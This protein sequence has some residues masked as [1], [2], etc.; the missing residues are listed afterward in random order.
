MLRAE[1]EGRPISNSSNFWSNPT[2][3]AGRDRAGAWKAG[4]NGRR[5]G[6]G[7]GVSGAEQESFQDDLASAGNQNGSWSRSQRD[8]F[9]GTGRERG[10]GR[11]RG[12]SRGRDRDRGSRGRGGG[13]SWREGHAAE[14]ANPSETWPDLG[15]ATGAGQ[16]V[17]TAATTQVPSSTGETTRG[18]SR[19]E[20]GNGARGGKSNPSGWGQPGPGEREM[21][22]MSSNLED[23]QNQRGSSSY[24][25]GP[26]DWDDATAG[27]QSKGNN[28]SIQGQRRKP[29]WHS[30]GAPDAFEANGRDVAGRV[31]SRGGRG[32]RRQSPSRPRRAPPVHGKGHGASGERRREDGGRGQGSSSGG[33]KDRNQTAKPPASPR[34]PTAA[35]GDGTGWGKPNSART[36]DEEVGGWV[37]TEEVAGSSLQA[38]ATST[39]PTRSNL[40][41]T[42]APPL[43]RSLPSALTADAKQWTGASRSREDDASAAA[44]I[45][46]L[47]ASVALLPALSGPATATA[48][49]TAAGVASGARVAFGEETAGYAQDAIPMNVTAAAEA[50]AGPGGAAIVA[51]GVEFGVGGNG[52]GAVPLHLQ[53]PSFVAPPGG[54]GGVGG[55]LGSSGFVEGVG[56]ETLMAPLSHLPPDQHA[57]LLHAHHQHLVAQVRGVVSFPSPLL[58]GD[59]TVRPV[60]GRLELGS[61][62]G[63]PEARACLTLRCVLSPMSFCACSVS[64]LVRA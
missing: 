39:A 54:G 4:G 31:T 18:G 25:E 19:I 17:S 3:K 12:G 5:G 10:R 14:S 58:C 22:G 51:P 40:E 61:M 62:H 6:G 9:E 47:T 33:R 28:P 11:G 21:W 23:E 53:M 35:C 52:S 41:R 36:V 43:P 2:G 50:G 45:S 20:S 48:T 13:G 8:G 59:V 55:S 63:E 16:G 24:A 46:T 38:A 60:R 57:M 37:T 32:D 27:K 42:A 7:S 26:N 15:R 30:P 49:T 29:E 56:I 64:I 1:E 44:A 34:A